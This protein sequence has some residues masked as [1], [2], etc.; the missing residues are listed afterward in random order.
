M[1]DLTTF[2][3]EELQR[4][5]LFDKDSDYDGMIGESVLELVQTFAK[6]GHSGFSA[7]LTLHIFN[8]VASYKPLGPINNNP[9]EWNEITDFPIEGKP[10]HQSK[11]S[12]SVFSDDNLQTWYDI[13]EK[14][15]WWWVNRIFGW[16]RRHKFPTK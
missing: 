14:L 16:R 3:K 1:T 10:L 6:Q 5:G 12:P 4:N 9:D 15:P 13:D 8:K 11:R 2:A 7:G